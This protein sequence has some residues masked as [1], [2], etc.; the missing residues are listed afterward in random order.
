MTT[1]AGALFD[2]QRRRWDIY[3]VGFERDEECGGRFD[4]FFSR[5][6]VSYLEKW[7]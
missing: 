7:R 5:V 2:G 4:V 3:L 1:D 6:R